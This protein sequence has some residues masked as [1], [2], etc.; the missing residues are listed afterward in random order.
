MTKD[1]AQARRENLAKMRADQKRKERRASLLMWGVG[2][3]VIVVLVGL[4]G[5]YLINQRSQSSLDAVTTTKYPG[6]VHKETKITY[7]EQPPVGGEHNSKWQ[8][9]GIYQEP[10]NN[11]NAVHSMEHGAVW[12]TYRPDLPKAQVE[13]LQEVAGADL[14]LLSPYPGLPA[15]VVASSWNNQL[16][17]TGADDPR[18]PRFISKYKNNP[19][20]T[21]EFGAPC[22]GGTD[23][24]A[25]QS[26]I[27]DA[28]PSPTGTAEPSATGSPAPSETGAAEP[29]ATPT[30]GS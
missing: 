5:F 14:V 24:T 3:L 18:L 27:P 12:I 4:V 2:G 8:N 16:K 9:C 26:P 23:A 21:P 15:P 25:A 20:T 22:T 13:Q 6:S 11:E 19:Q 7:A 30:A 10:L 29:S 1:R 28:A 17:L